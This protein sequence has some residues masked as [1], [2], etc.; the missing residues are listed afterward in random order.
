M[1]DRDSRSDDFIEGRLGDVVGSTQIS[2]LLSVLFGP[3]RLF[4]DYIF[5]VPR[6]GI[7][8]EFHSLVNIEWKDF[9]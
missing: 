1:H 7:G 9:L 3:F 4:R 5:Q 6:N 8:K 2:G